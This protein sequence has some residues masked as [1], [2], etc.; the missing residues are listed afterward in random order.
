MDFDG[1][2]EEPEELSNANIFSLKINNVYRDYFEG[3]MPYP[4]T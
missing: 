4:H 2:E 1:F 3:N